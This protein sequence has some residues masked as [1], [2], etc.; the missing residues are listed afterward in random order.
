MDDSR[1]VVTV[2]RSTDALAIH[3]PGDVTYLG[4]IRELVCDLA[5]KVGFPSEDIAKIEMAVDEACS[6]IVEHAYAPDTNWR[7]QH[8]RPEIRL[9]VRIAQDQLIIE[10]NDHGQQFDFA[11]Y[12]PTNVHDRA[13]AMHTG[14]YGIAIMRE[15]MDE[16]AYISNAAEGNTLRLVKYLK[17]T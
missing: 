12:R 9:V 16:V 4:H 1:P 7:W 3:T 5:H 14:G 10:I 13:Q 6:N 2:K 15:F 11:A 17:K 8:Q